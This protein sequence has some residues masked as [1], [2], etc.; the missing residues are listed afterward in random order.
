MR[1]FSVFRV[2]E[3]GLSRRRWDFG[4]SVDHEG[5]ALILDWYSVERRNTA[6]GRFSK[7]VANDRWAAM[8][9]RRYTSGL[10]RPVNIPGD[11]LDEAWAS[12]PRSTYIGWRTDEHKLAA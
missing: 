9:E 5:F 10:S 3:D 2:S 4:T 7:A 1:R 12:V 8:D 11:V 6:R